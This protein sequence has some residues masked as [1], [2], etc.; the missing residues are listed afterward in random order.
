MCI[1]DR[2]QVTVRYTD[3]ATG[4][5][6]SVDIDIGRV[7]QLPP[8]A[9]K[10][11]VKLR[12]SEQREIVED[13][14]VNNGINSDRSTIITE[15]GSYEHG[16]EKDDSDWMW[17]SIS[18]DGTETDHKPRCFVANASGKEITVRLEGDDSRPIH[19][20]HR[21]TGTLEHGRIRITFEG[22]E[23]VILRTVGPRTSLIVFQQNRTMM[24]GKLYGEDIEDKKWIVDG[25]N[26]KPKT[27]WQ[28]FIDFLNKIGEIFKTLFI[29]CFIAFLKSLTSS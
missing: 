6:T 13:L 5:S 11:S 25:S 3:S 16:Y 26:Y 17:K 2:Y 28:E 1:R 14:A 7:Y 19:I 10:L 22:S 15:E 24:T 20:A 29:P 9:S 12:D 18:L 23:Q 8:S 27:K 21:E 4:Q